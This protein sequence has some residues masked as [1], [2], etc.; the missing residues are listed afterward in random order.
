MNLYLLLNTLKV[1]KQ[2]VLII[3][4]YSSFNETVILNFKKTLIKIPAF[5]NEN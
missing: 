4:F 2:L 3:K 1:L 5:V